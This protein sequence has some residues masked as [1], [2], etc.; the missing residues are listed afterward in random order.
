[1]LRASLV[2]LAVCTLLLWLVGVVDGATTWMVWVDGVVAVLTLLLVPVT[3]DRVGAIGVAI[4]P[5]LLGLGLIAVFIVGLATDATAWITWFTLAWGIGY[6]LFA[7]F[8]F[9]LRTVEPRMVSQ[10]P[11]TAQ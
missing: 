10:R 8:A 6:L 3:R 9:M 2:S 11:I 1:M 4:G 5:T 7:G